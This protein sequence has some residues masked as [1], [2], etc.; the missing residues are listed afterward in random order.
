MVMET[1]GTIPLWVIALAGLGV[2]FWLFCL[3][4]SWINPDAE[5][6]PAEAYV[7]N[8][9]WDDGADL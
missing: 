2:Q 3:L 9:D 1:I 5:A 6:I 7:T 8:D 4:P